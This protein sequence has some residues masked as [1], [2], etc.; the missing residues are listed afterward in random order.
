MSSN[1]STFEALTLEAIRAAGPKGIALVDPKVNAPTARKLAEKGLVTI[2]KGS[3]PS[4]VE[5]VRV[6]P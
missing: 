1:L 6:K 5:M 4:H 3:Q 2:S